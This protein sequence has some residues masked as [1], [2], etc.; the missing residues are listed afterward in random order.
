MS[1]KRIT[2]DRLATLKNKLCDLWGKILIKS[3]STQEVFEELGFKYNN[4][5]DRENLYKYNRKWQEEA[6]AEWD[7]FEIIGGDKEV[8]FKKWLDYCYKNKLPYI[9]FVNRMALSPRTYKEWERILS[10]TCI[11]KLYGT[12]K[13]L[14]RMGIKSMELRYNI[15]DLHGNKIEYQIS[16]TK[17][18][19]RHDKTLKLIEDETKQKDLDKLTP[20][21]LD[22]LAHKIEK[23]RIER[24]KKRLKDK[25]ENNNEET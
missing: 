21:E 20:E 8:I 16:T 9:L 19:S 12:R 7:K 15:T 22:Q 4:T 5:S 1:K 17:L 6:E 25:V 3:I 2:S 18:L 11:R 14:L 10:L 24:A 13:S 23:E